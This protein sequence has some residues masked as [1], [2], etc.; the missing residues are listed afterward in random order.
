MKKWTEKDT[1]EMIVSIGVSCLTAIIVV[2]A[3]TR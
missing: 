3:A 2:L 1:I